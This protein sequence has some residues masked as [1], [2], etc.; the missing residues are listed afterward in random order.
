MSARTLFTIGHS[1]RT[2]NEFFAILQES[3]IQQ[4]I[5]VR[6][7]PQSRRYPS[8]NRNTLSMALEEED[9]AYAWLGHELGGIR[10]EKTNSPHSA[11]AASSFKGYADHMTS[12]AFQAGI[13]KLTALAQKQPVAIMCA[14]RDPTQC[15]RSL[16]ADYLTLQGWH[17]IHLLEPHQACGHCLNPL[18]RAENLQPIYDR[19]EQEQLDLSL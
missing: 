3:G 10:R 7:H 17:I 9:I 6:S 18:A 1:N 4:L 19:L 16:I 11:L 2:L 5:D 15:H 12:K 8:F 14:E 13:E